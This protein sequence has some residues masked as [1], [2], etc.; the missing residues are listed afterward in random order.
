[1][2]NNSRYIK[3]PVH[4]HS[5]YIKFK[6]IHLHFLRNYGCINTFQIA[7][8]GILRFFHF[9]FNMFIYFKCILLVLN[10]VSVTHSK[11][12]CWLLLFSHMNSIRS[13]RWGNIISKVFS[14]WLYKCISHE[15]NIS[16]LCA[17]N[18]ERIEGFSLHIRFS[19]R[20]KLWFDI[21]FNFNTIIMSANAESYRILLFLN[22]IVVIAHE[23]VPIADKTSPIFL[24]Y[25]PFAIQSCFVTKTVTLNHTFVNLHYN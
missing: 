19:S 21:I 8:N 14:M 2:A 22:I 16:C 13:N 3:W 18:L 9:M 24:S 12:R 20:T 25:I 11:H 4:S 7:L 15:C 23:Y 1:M 6:F 5:H 17:R 10:V